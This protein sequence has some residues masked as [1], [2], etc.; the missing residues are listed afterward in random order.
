[1]SAPALSI[2][3]P[4]LNDAAALERTLGALVRGGT[5][6][7][8]VIVVD[9]GDDP[10]CAAA[11]S[12]HGARY[13]RVAPGR[14]RQMNAGAERARGRLLL[15]LHAD[16]RLPP[17]ALHRVLQRCAR[18]ASCWGRFDVTLDAHGWPFRVI[19]WAMNSRSRITGIATGDQAL[20]V[21]RALFRE[22]GGYPTIEL[23]EDIALSA[24]L[25][26]AEPPVCLRERVVTSARRWQRGGVVATMVRM[27]VLRA[28]Y[29]CGV[30][31][32]TLARWYR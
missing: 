9:G 32:G 28:A 6:G 1:V 5:A 15:F 27:W 23:M 4:V 8:E 29:A 10:A 13:L 31:A 3:I 22:V 25:R 11:A 7:C 30:A 19:E 26:A 17:G 14:A 18:G 2:V 20:F 21:A 16:T 24:R 12:A